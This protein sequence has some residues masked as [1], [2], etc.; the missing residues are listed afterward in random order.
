M[1]NSLGRNQWMTARIEAEPVRYPFSFTVL[2]DSAASPTPLGDALFGEML[3]QM[4][5]LERRPLFLANLGDFSGPGTRDRHTQYLRLV[6]SCSFPNLCVMGNH[7]M[8][9]PTGWENFRSVHGPQNYRFAYGH[10][11]FVALNCQP[12]TEGLREDDL[13]Y[14]ESALSN[15]D[16]PHQVLLMHMPPHFGGHYAPHEEW[17]FQKDEGEF[18]EIL[19]KHRV[20][21]VCCAHVIGYDLHHWQGIPFVV[22]G[23]GG[24]GV[25]SHYGLCGGGKPPHRGSFFHFVEVTMEESGALTGRVYRAFEGTHADPAYTFSADTP[26]CPAP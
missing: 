22:S 23:G 21:L 13:A 25:C 26:L 8:D 16:H 15:D 9:D 14:L 20:R 5:R 24:W 6:E 19:S 10:T 17:S 2:G 7:D 12:G 4:E 11:L 3:R 1:P 18:L